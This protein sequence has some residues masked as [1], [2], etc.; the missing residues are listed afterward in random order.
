M[1]ATPLEAIYSYL[2]N[3]GGFPE[4]GDPSLDAVYY[5]AMLHGA[6]QRM[7]QAGVDM[8]A[9]NKPLITQAVNRAYRELVHVRSRI[10]LDWLDNSVY[11]RYGRLYK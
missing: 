3:K 2:Q 5:L 10:N 9:G 4:T 8:K 11:S 1:I 7:E 6:I